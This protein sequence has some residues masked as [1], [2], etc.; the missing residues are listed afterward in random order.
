MPP[1]A[2][3]AAALISLVDDTD[4]RRK[5]AAFAR[6]YALSQTWDAIME[7]LRDRYR[8]V[9]ARPVAAL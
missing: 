1:P 5:M 7:S 3:F 6:A 9:I 4:R 2:A 8:A